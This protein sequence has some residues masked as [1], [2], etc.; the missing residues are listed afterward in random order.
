[1]HQDIQEILVSEKEIKEITQ[2]LG[3][4][5][6]VDYEGKRPLFVGLLNG[7]IPF[8]SE[9]VLKVD[10]PLEIQFMAVS[11]YHGGIK[12]SGDVNI[13]YDLNTSVQDRDV[14]IVEDIVDT[15]ST[16]STITKLLLHRGAKSIKVVTLLDKPSGRVVDFIPDYIG[17]TI[18]PKFV[19]GYGLDYNEFYRNLPYIGVLKPD[20]YTK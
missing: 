13:K 6:S 7:C 10:I 4:Q 17:V 18:P 8:M 1:M 3:R 19:V 2:R 11:S 16:L 14:V 5:L 9:L 15:G 12:S 20:V